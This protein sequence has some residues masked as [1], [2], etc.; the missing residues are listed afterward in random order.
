MSVVLKATGS[1][2]RVFKTKKAATAVMRRYK[3]LH[4]AAGWLSHGSGDFYMFKEAGTV[5]FS[6]AII[7][8]DTKR[9]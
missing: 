6:K 7:V 1:R 2:G 9:V 5:G 8:K 3:A 4:L